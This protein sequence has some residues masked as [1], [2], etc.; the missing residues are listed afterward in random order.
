MVP[1]YLR[2]AKRVPVLSKAYEDDISNHGYG[3]F[4]FESVGAKI[5]S[6]TRAV[7]QTPTGSKIRETG[8][9]CT[10]RMLIVWS[11]RRQCKMR[12]WYI[13]KSLVNFVCF[14]YFQTQHNPMWSQDTDMGPHQQTSKAVYIKCD[15]INSHCSYK[16]TNCSL[17]SFYKCNVSIQLQ[18][19]NS[20]H[21]EICLLCISQLWD[22][23]FRN[24]IH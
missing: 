1:F 21:W 15:L 10:H 22:R 11:W 19:E 17:N 3:H 20:K 16:P 8:R 18:L 12:I 2:L 4:D 24:L 13:K 5:T 6:S 9:I 7:N 23:S 14:D